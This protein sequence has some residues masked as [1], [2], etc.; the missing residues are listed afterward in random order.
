[1]QLDLKEQFN[2]KWLFVLADIESAGVL[3]ISEIF[4]VDLAIAFHFL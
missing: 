4:G 3:P 2:P 1:M